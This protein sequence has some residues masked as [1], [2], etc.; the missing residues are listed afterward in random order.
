VVFLGGIGVYII[1]YVLKMSI[2]FLGKLLFYGVLF[3]KMVVVL[4]GVVIYYDV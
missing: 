1:V 4:G 3:G 2:M